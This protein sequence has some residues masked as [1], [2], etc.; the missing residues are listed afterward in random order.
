M[1]Q[2]VA[3]EALQD[4]T[5]GRGLARLYATGTMQ[6]FT[7]CAVRAARVFGC[8]KR[9]SHSATTSLTGP[10]DYLPPEEAEEAERPFRITYGDSQDKR[11]DLQQFVFSTR[12]VDRAVPLGGK[13][14]DGHAS[15]KTVHNP[16]L[17]DL[18]TFLA[19]HGVAAGAYL[20]GADAA[21]V[22][23][24]NLATLGA[25][26]F[27]TRFPATSSACGRLIAEAVAHNAWEEVGV[28]AHTKPTQ[29]RPVTFYTTEA[30]QGPLYGTPYRAVVVHA[31]A[32]GQTAATAAGP[33]YPGLL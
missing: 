33:G 26:L 14:H 29:P 22:T 31:S 9:Y 4:D 20:S 3:P 6:V 28:L 11:P 27:I 21:L 1:G 10:G 2:A 8:D 17:S 16:L 19:T 25:T 13:P 24:D 32:P 18:A 5:V 30:G 12:C 23:A 7:A 15:E